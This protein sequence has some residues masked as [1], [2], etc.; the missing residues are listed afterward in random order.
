MTVTLLKDKDFNIVEEF[1]P[2]LMAKLK[3]PDDDLQHQLSKNVPIKFPKKMKECEIDGLFWGASYI[4]K[5]CK[6]E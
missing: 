6:V 3:C 4:S 5:R 1:K 2:S